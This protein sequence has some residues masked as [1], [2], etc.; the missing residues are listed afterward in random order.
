M[1]KE[2]TM[3]NIKNKP[4]RI[5]FLIIYSSRICLIINREFNMKMKVFISSII[6]CTSFLSISPV[7]SNAEAGPIKWLLKIFKKE[8]NIR[9]PPARVA[10]PAV[11]KVVT[12]YYKGPSLVKMTAAT[13][14]GSVLFDLGIKQLDKFPIANEVE[15]AMQNGNDYQV[16]VCRN[17]QGDMFALPEDFINCP[18]GDYSITHGPLLQYAKT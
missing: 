9:T 2:F 16:R 3:T 18:F 13:A 15:V 12:T 14:L 10:A 7:S 4:Y 8:N 17:S 5:L 6:L 11:K 1:S